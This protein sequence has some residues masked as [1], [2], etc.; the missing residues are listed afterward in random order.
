LSAPS[1]CSRRARSSAICDRGLTT[2][3]VLRQLNDVQGSDATP[4]LPRRLACW[5][6]AAAVIEEKWDFNIGTQ[7]QLVDPS[8]PTQRDEDQ[9]RHA[10]DRLPALPRD[11]LFRLAKLIASKGESTCR[12]CGKTE[13]TAVN[14]SLVGSYSS[15]A[16]P[17]GL[18]LRFTRVHHGL[19]PLPPIV[20]DRFRAAGNRSRLHRSHAD[21]A[22]ADYAD[23]DYADTAGAQYARW[24]GRCVRFDWVPSGGD[25]AVHLTDGSGSCGC[26]PSLMKT[27]RSAS[28]R[29]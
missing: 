13:Q 15:A 14:A 2:I 12:K 27:S 23:A 22:D 19:P 24:N 7:G 21:Y 28:S 4:R 10:P 5:H 3:D 29:L 26:D 9:G 16:P 8:A 6:G 25:R 20:Q 18:I 1:G 11:D 17:A